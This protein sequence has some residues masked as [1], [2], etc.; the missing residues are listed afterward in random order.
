ISPINYELVLFHRIRIYSV[1]H[2]LLLEPVA[3]K[4]LANNTTEVEN[5]ELEYK[6]K[7]ILKHRSI[8]STREYLIK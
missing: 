5:N 8:N 4:I 7:K 2:I 6:M 1:F 3:Q